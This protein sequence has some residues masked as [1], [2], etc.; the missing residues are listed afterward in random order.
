MKRT[1]ANARSSSE[2]HADDIFPRYRV[3]DRAPQPA[4]D[5]TESVP[6]VPTPV[7]GR[8]EEPESIP[9]STTSHVSQGSRYPHLD[10]KIPD[11]YM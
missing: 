9:E 4:N 2:Q 8:N 3:V 1:S 10:R 11:C 5:R 7:V 6:A